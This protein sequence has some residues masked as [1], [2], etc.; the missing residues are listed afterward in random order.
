MSINDRIEKVK[1]KIVTTYN[2]QLS[3]EL[4]DDWVKLCAIR[5]TIDDRINNK[6]SDEYDI[7]K[8]LDAI[9]PIFTDPVRMREN[10][11][12]EIRQLLFRVRFG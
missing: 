2:E 7:Q 5:D 6:K 12:Y 4:E 8:T 1:Q 11:N 9:E 3:K 10:S